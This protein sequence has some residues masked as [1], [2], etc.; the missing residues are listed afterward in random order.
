MKRNSYT[1]AKNPYSVLGFLRRLFRERKGIAGSV[2]AFLLLWVGSGYA[3]AAAPPGDAKEVPA[4]SY[5][6][7]PVGKADPFRPFV[8]KEPVVKKKAEKINAS[9]IFPLQKAG[10]DQFNLVG[11]IG[12]AERRLAIVE[13][14]DNKG[15]FYP[16][17][18]GT[19]I[20]LNN[21]KVVEIKSDMIVIEELTKGSS[22]QK[23][24]RIKIKLRK[25]EEGTP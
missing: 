13:A 6:Y 14:T 11:I 10:L 16:L 2:V 22:R 19:I 17:A 23:V 5:H 4:A 18:L 25:E 9:S 12:D 1:F 3:A 24:N 15:K 21:G 20:G 7:N 8:E